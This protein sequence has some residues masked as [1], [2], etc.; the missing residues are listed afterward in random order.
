[1]KEIRKKRGH[2]VNLSPLSTL[3]TNIGNLVIIIIVYVGLQIHVSVFKISA[4]NLFSFLMKA[5]I[6]PR[7]I[8]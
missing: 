3:E 8:M 4:Q 7:L 5:F 6:F 1:M 2:R